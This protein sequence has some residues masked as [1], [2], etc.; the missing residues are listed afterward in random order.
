L[1]VVFGTFCGTQTVR[2][3]DTQEIEPRT[4]DLSVEAMAGRSLLFKQAY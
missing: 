3:Y 1:G 2:E 4:T